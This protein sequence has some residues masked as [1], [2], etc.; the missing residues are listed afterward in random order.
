LFRVFV[1]GK[2]IFP[3]K[4]LELFSFFLLFLWFNYAPFLSILVIL[5]IQNCQTWNLTNLLFLFALDLFSIFIQPLSHDTIIWEK[6]ENFFISY[7]YDFV[8]MFVFLLFQFHR[9]IAEDLGCDLISTGGCRFGW[10]INYV[11]PCGYFFKLPNFLKPNQ[12]SFLL[13]WN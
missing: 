6:I 8:F 5:N 13:F 4:L 7:E 9:K 11:Y 1:F 12:S 10:L 2:I 3:K